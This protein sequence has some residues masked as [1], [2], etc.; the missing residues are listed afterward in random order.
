MSTIAEIVAKIATPLAEGLGF[1]LVDVEFVKEG[2]QMVLRIFIDIE[3]GITIDHC[4]EM[5]QALSDE[6]D[7]IDPIEQNYHLEVSSPGIERPLKKEADFI[8]F[9]GE[10]AT[11]KL[12][13]PLEGR[14]KYTGILCGLEDDVILL[15]DENK[16][17]VKIPRS[18]V[19]KANLAFV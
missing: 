5:S 9:I 16:N 12:F 17:M 14:K 2:S 8:R 11:L 18:Q 7:R 1:E 19:A 4:K 10:A 13:A 3:G 15:E 6:L